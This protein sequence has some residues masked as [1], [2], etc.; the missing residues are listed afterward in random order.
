MNWIFHLPVLFATTNINFANQFLLMNFFASIFICSL[1]F[2]TN[3]FGQQSFNAH[4]TEAENKTLQVYDAYTGPQAALYN[5]PEYVP[6][7]FKREG[8]TFYDSD[9]LTTG[10]ISYDHYLYREIPIQYDVTREQVIVLNFDKRSRLFLENSRIDS[11]YYGGHTFINLAQNTEQNLA[12]SGFYERAVSGEISVFV[13][14]R[15]TIKETIKESQV[16]R[17]FNNADRI[18]L[19]K[20][21]K[22]F[23]VKNKDDVFR[24]IGDKRNEVKS[25][26]RRLQIKIRR[27][28]FEEAVLVAVKIYDQLM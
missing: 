12:A 13:L 15:K 4:T 11:F 22:Y 25:E 28:N 1:F 10:W 24:V 14:R 27:K 5:G 19:K 8:T 20:H 3:S 26:M 17:V 18:F 9:T 21:D 7:L 6:F 2:C 23:E 16:V